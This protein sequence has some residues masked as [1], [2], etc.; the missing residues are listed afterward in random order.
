MGL[1]A[2]AAGGLFIGASAWVLIRLSEATYYLAQAGM[3][4]ALPILLMIGLLSGIAGS[5]MDSLLGA[6][7][8]VMYRCGQCG[9]EI[10][11]T[12]HC[13]MPAKRI[14]GF[15]WMTNDA[16]NAMSSLI[17]GGIALL[18]ILFIVNEAIM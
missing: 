2:S 12:N 16:V 17:G 1:G 6:T 3:L 18:L 7:V 13:D 4:T 15:A 5:L 14:R 9:K 8:Q 10:E 11:K